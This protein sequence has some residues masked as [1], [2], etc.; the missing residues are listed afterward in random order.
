MAVPGGTFAR[1]YDVGTD[2]IY[3]DM[4]NTA[5]IRDFRL[6]TYEV[7]IGR[8]RQFLDAGMGT[9][10][11]PPPAGAGARRLNLADNQAGWDPAWNTNL[12][13]DTAALTSEIVACSAAA[14][15]GWTPTPDVN[16]ARPMVCIDWY[17]AFAFCV[18]DG[19]FLPTE[20]EWNYAAAGGA[21]QRAYPWSNP[22]SDINVACP[23]AN[24]A[25][26]TV[27]CVNRTTRVGSLSPAGDAR[28]GHADMAGNAIEWV[29]DWYAAYPLPCDDC[30]NLTPAALRVFRGGSYGFDQTLARTAYRNSAAGDPTMAH[31]DFGVRCARR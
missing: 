24:I 27:P 26:S 5:T 22:P 3:F 11:N 23:Q 29:L 7:T 14:S 20:A 16:D 25:P 12:H 17:A 4:T 18:W 10:Q 9:Q 2:G 31:G 19:G 21:E 15:A 6:D 1:S 28:W 30:A 8:F 13:V